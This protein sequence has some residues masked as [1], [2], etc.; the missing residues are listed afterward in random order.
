MIYNGSYITSFQNKEPLDSDEKA[1]VILVGFISLMVFLFS[2]LFQ[3]LFTAIPSGIVL[4]LCLWILFGNLFSV[5]RKRQG[6]NELRQIKERY[7]DDWLKTS[8]EGSWKIK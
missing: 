3:C 5:Y 6:E 8:K 4:Y 7:G 2:V 1:K